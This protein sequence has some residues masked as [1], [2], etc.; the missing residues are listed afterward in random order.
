MAKGTGFRVVNWIAIVVVAAVTVPVLA[1]GAYHLVK[2]IALP[3]AYGWDYLAADT[4]GRRLY[5]SH[6][7]E[8]VVLDLDSGA[9]LGRIAGGTDM[10]GVAVVPALGRGFISDTNPGS[11]V[12]FDLK[13]FARIAEVAVGKDPNAI[14]FDH[15]TGRVFTAD[16][17]SQRVTAIDAKTGKVAGA[18]NNLGGRTEHAVSDEAGHV[19]LNL[20]D[21]NTLLRLDAQ[22]LT[23]LNVWPV[24]PCGLPSSMDIDRAHERVFIGCR[25][26]LMAVVDA[27]S[28][29]VVD[30]HPIGPGVD[31][32]EFDAARGLVYFSSGG[33]D[34]S[35]WVFHQEAPDTY[36]LVEQVPTQPGARTMALDRK[37]GR[38]F[39]SVRAPGGL[40]VL[41]FGE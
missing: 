27:R 40:S 30:T 26:G 32:T 36:T 16:R 34:G 38:V 10:H 24:T 3:G 5:V 39:L 21:K 35:L 2:T 18:I 14:F 29:R 28:G 33:G 7:R 37:T 23:V 4:D 13:T 19:F 20:Q 1:A 17:G 12:I 9:T 11:V 22:G 8:I 25:S 31:A 6:E 41:E 15:K